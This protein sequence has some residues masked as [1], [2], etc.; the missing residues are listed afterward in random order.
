MKKRFL[1][2]SLLS[3]I[4]F[5][6]LMGCAA[7]HPPKL[8]PFS[9]TQFDTRMYN[10]KVDSFLILF[11]ASS[12]MRH[13]F[14]DTP[15]FVIAKAIAERMNMTIPEMGQTG[16]L[17]CFGH[18][19]EGSDSHTELYYGMTR[20]TTR[21]M[22]GGLKHLASPGG[23]SPLGEAMDAAQLDLH[24][25]GG[26]K[27]VIIITDGQDMEK[28]LAQA[29]ALKDKFGSNICFYPIQV[30]DPIPIPGCP[31]ERTFLQQIADIGD[32]SDHG[33]L[34][35]AD[36]V[37][38]SAGMASFVEKVF[39]EKKDTDADGVH[40]ITDKCP[41]SPENI[42]VND[43]GCW[44]LNELLFKFNK[45][46]INPIA[47]PKLDE[48][49][50]HMKNNPRMRVE[51]QGHTD[52]IGSEAYNMNLSLRRANAVANYLVRKGV[53]RTRM[54]TTG[55]GF[56]SPVALNSTS[57]GRALNRRVDIRPY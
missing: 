42:R 31:R 6:F 9:A 46:I 25:T 57:F 12:S 36:E 19:E 48:V 8:P 37:L 40:N 45:T 44:T 3:V 51:I 29:Q 10:L 39:L 35:T 47:Y 2:Q 34:V 22:M 14:K 5:L 30:G 53:S 24:K 15:K 18:A 32:H 1:V 11:D 13:D 20:Y 54:V 50:R 33:F 41:E 56:K 43:S 21:G 55:F 38:T 52:N 17:R 23:T 16:G 7:K 4:V 49:A 28:T 27:A 26:H